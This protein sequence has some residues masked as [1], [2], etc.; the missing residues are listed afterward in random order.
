MVE[1]VQHCG[2]R[3]IAGRAYERHVGLAGGR[4]ANHGA[5]AVVCLC[6]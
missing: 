4:G 5:P 6:V 3:R 2:G 1:L